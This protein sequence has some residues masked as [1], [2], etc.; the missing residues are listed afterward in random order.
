M[1]LDN[2]HHLDEQELIQ[3][4]VDE[5]DLPQTMQA[6]LVT[7]HQCRASKESFE[8]DL[9][10]LGQMAERYAPKPQKRI[11]IP[12]H[13][14][15]SAFWTF[16]NW[17]T[18]IGAAATVAAVLIVF[19]G[20]TIV[21]NLTEYGTDSVPAELMQAKQLMTEVNMLVDNALP[22]LYLKISA[23]NNP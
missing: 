15:R 2:E 21:R 18:A 7:C 11:A 6:H 9:A 19:W 22:P 17:R 12:V 13:E 4:V 23:E 14:P 20:T 5:S 10:S 16:F 3:A 1:N 8:Q